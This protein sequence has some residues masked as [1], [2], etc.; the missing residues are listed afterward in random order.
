M[1]ALASCI[2]EEIIDDDGGVW[3]VF[4]MLLLSLSSIGFYV[5]E[6]IR[7]NVVII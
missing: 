1:V 6:N 5:N 4:L 7:V 2:V 3:V